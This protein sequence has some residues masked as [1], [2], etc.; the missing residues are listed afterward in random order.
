MCLRRRG[1]RVR[2][3]YP[4]ADLGVSSGDVKVCFGSGPIMGCTMATLAIMLKPIPGGWA[5]CL[6]DG[7]QVAQFRGPR[8]R[9]RALRYLAVAGARG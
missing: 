1:F 8:A 2:S 5:V 7:H 6:T 3:R 4:G 9:A